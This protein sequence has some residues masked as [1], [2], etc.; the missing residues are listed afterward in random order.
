MMFIQKKRRKI[1]KNVFIIV[2]FEPFQKKARNSQKNDMKNSKAQ[3]EKNSTF[4]F[5]S[6]NVNASNFINFLA[7]SFFTNTASR[8]TVSIE[9]DFDMNIDLFITSEEE[10]S[11]DSNE[12]ISKTSSSRKNK[13]KIDEFFAIQSVVDFEKI[14][15]LKNLSKNARSKLMTKARAFFDLISAEEESKIIE[16]NEKKFCT[17]ITIKHLH[18]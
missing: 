18:P 10:T 3:S 5:F 16:L 15:H 11:K 1:F 2:D 6:E 17:K 7:R 14:I 8:R 9:F 4:Q 12:K 13:Q